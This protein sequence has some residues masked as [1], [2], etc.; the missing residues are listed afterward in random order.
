MEGQYPVL[1]NGQPCGKVTVNRQGLYYRIRCRCQ[2]PSQDICRLQAVSGTR[3]E[4]LG[5]LVPAEDGFG[6]DT[7]I[8]VKRLGEGEP[9]FSLSTGQ[10]TTDSRFVP[11]LDEEPFAYIARLK[12][13]FLE[14]ENGQMGIRITEH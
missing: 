1:L 2:I 3:R 10:E 5:V 4:N 11:I 7:R 9:A 14:F 8:P 6:L 13:S 12:E